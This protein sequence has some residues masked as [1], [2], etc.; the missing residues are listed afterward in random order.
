MLCSYA[1][2]LSSQYYTDYMYSPVRSIAKASCSGH[3][4]NI[5]VGVSVG[6]KSTVVPTI[7]ISITVVASY[8]LG[9]SSGV[10]SG[11]NA[12]LFGTAVATMSMLSTAGY[13]LSMNNYGPI[14]DNAGGIA[15]MSHQH[16]SVRDTTDRLDAAGNV[17][18]AMTKG[19]SIGSAALSHAS[20]SL[21]P[22]WMSF[23]STRASLSEVWTWRIPRCS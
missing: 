10:G 4:V 13:I 7:A 14:A 16:A 11:R 20:S 19:Y 5:I 17:T 21:A 2:V 12:G 1:F 15:E 22:S 18:K 6:M 9:V 3:G 8:L 23:Q